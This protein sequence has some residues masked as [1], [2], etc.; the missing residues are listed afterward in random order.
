MCVFCKIISGQIPSYKVYED[1]HV[2]AFLDIAPVTKGHTLVIPKKHY[3]NI[4]ELDEKEAGIL[5]ERVVMLSK[6]IKTG[7]NVENLNVLNNNGPLAYQSVDHYHI[8][9][10]PRYDNDSFKI[11]FP[12]EKLTSEEMMK[13]A[14]HISK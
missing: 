14:M 9:L 8:H 11:K 1:D 10:I 4:F 5:Y 13:I 6:K 7:L 3:S 2:F 12:E